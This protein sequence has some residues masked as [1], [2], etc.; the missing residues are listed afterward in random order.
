MIELLL[1]DPWWVS[2]K[3]HCLTGVPEYVGAFTYGY[4]QAP[5]GHLLYIS[6]VTTDEGSQ[7]YL[8]TGAGC[9]TYNTNIRGYFDHHHCR[10]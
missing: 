8:V 5:L 1:L 7:G 10:Y 4:S 9:Y 3:R 2:K 6:G